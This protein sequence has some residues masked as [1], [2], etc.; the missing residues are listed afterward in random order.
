MPEAATVTL[1][2][3]DTNSSEDNHGETPACSEPQRISGI[4]LLVL[5]QLP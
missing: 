3:A 2:W 1:S 4:V 5:S